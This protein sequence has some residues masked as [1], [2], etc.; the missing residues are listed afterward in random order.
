MQD[1]T[2]SCG[3]GR[4]MRL[5]ALRGKGAFRCGCGARVRIDIPPYE[6]ETCVARSRGARCLATPQTSDPV[7]LCKPHLKD[8]QVAFGLIKPED[9]DEYLLR[10][11]AAEWA[12]IEP[13]DIKENYLAALADRRARESAE[14]HRRMVANLPKGGLIPASSVVYYIQFGDRIKIGTTTSLERRLAELPHDELLATESGGVQT[15]RRRHEQFEAYR[16]LG[17]WFEMGEELVDHIN[18]LRRQQFVKDR[19]PK[20]RR[21][22]LATPG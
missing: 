21:R 7:P 19:V 17:E 8:M 2:V 14:A 1:V 10:R 3:C 18:E 20:A 22:Y 9:A 4:K 5:D 16:L 12:A 13:G 15:E 11:A 6:A